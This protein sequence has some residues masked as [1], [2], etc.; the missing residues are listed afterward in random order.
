MMSTVDW[1]DG[2]KETELGPLPAD[3]EVVRLG[4]EIELRTD[5]NSQGSSF[6]VYTVSNVHGFV[7]SDQFFEKRVYSR[8]LGPYKIIMKDDFAYNPYR[9]NVGS[10]GLFR[11]EEP[12]LVSPAYTVFRTRPGGGINPEFLFL[13]LKSEQY[14]NEIRRFAMSRGSVRRSLAF[15]D[16]TTFPVPL[17][18]LAEQRA[19]A[20]VL[21]AIQEAIGAT[22][23]VIAATQELKRSLMRHLFTY[24][25]VPPAEADRVPLQETEIGEMPEHW[26]VARLGEVAK[27][28]RKPKGLDVSTYDSIPFIPM[29]L[30]P[31]HGISIR[32][33]TERAPDEISSGVYCEPGDI[34]LPKITPSF[35]NG[36][37]G[38]VG[39]LPI[40]FG[41]ATTEVY[42][43]KVNPHRLDRVFMF[44][45]LKMVSV[46]SDI[47]GK[48]EGTTGRQRVPKS[49]VQNYLIPLPPLPE[50][51]EIAHMLTT[52]DQRIEGEQKRKAAL[53]ALFQTMLQQLMTGRLRAKAL[54]APE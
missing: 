41:Y 26:E 33:Y 10:I 53:Q 54:E 38:V 13:L 52:L 30:I 39:N 45:L 50:Q 19:I 18:P 8:D 1:V 17:P 40:P 31:D 12:G 42:P 49:V 5:K 25:P 7:P 46:R 29:S 15:K 35:E 4:D 44:N 11:N 27:I 3:W 32:E 48:M 36:K 6:P 9:I 16:L 28:T 22:E 47:A 37:G 14:L 21:S 34:L 23:R 20:R 24:G 43:L 51:R 2:F